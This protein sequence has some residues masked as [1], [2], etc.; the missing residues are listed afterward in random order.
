MRRVSVLALLVCAT[1]AYAAPSAAGARALAQDQAATSAYPS[2]EVLSGF[3]KACADLSSIANAEAAAHAAG[4]ETYTPAKDSQVAQL[5]DF[6][7]TAAGKMAASDK[8]YK[9][10]VRVLRTKIGGRPF[11][12]MITGVKSFGS[13]SLGC[14]MVDFTATVPIETTAIDAWAKAI[15]PQ[16]PKA[17]RGNMENV[18]TTSM[19]RPGLFPGHDKTQVA[20]VPQTSEL[21]AVLHLSG[22]NLMTQT[23]N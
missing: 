1:S 5:L 20:F 17:V 22:N 3:A 4:W 2:T 15:A 8:D 18:L 9:T 11:D 21:K 14:R 7:M 13:Y 23:R 19:W 16:A 6:G 10:D 12:L